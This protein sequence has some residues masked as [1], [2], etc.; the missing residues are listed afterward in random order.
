MSPVFLTIP[1]YRIFF[2]ARYTQKTKP[3]Y[4]TYVFSGDTGDMWFFDRLSPILRCLGV[5]SFIFHFGDT[6]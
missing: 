6:C 1:I 4:I 5:T 2:Y 3:I